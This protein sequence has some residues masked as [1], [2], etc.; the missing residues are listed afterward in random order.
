M[1][2]IQKFLQKLS[3]NERNVIEGL[4][5]KVVGD[6][7]KGLD[8]KRL[9][10]EEGLYRVRKGNIRIIFLREKD[11]VRIIDIGRKNKNTFKNF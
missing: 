6:D 3:H 7:L 8:I 9:K 5:T 11:A 10:G 1:D 4:I 2:K